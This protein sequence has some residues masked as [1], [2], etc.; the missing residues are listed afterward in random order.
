MGGLQKRNG[1]P[2]VVNSLFNLPLFRGLQAE[3]PS[4][5]GENVGITSSPCLGLPEPSLWAGRGANGE[6]RRAA[7]DVGVADV[8]FAI[9]FPALARVNVRHLRG[10]TREKNRNG[11]CCWPPH[12]LTPPPSPKSPN[13]V[14]VRQR[15]SCPGHGRKTKTLKGEWMTY[16]FALFLV[17][18]L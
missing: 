11:I 10:K 16:D 13:Q 4:G 17:P 15:Q 3:P 7:G 8:Q 2:R 9:F 1:F 5:E 12:L 6:T 14:E 18:E